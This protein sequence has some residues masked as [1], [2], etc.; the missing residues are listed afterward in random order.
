M[1]GKPGRARPHAGRAPGIASCAAGPASAATR[2]R[3]APEWPQDDGTPRIASCLAHRLRACSRRVPRPALLDEPGLPR[4]EGGGQSWLA[5]HHRCPGS[6][7]DFEPTGGAAAFVPVAFP[8]LVGT[9][10]GRLEAAECEL[11]GPSDQFLAVCPV[12]VSAPADAGG[13]AE[14]LQCTPGGRAPGVAGPSGAPPMGM[15]RIISAA[16]PRSSCW[17]QRPA[18]PVS[19]AAG[20]APRTTS[21]SRYEAR[22]SRGYLVGMSLP[23]LPG[24]AALLER[25]D[26]LFVSRPQRRPR[27]AGHPPRR[28][29]FRFPRLC[30]RRSRRPVLAEP[31]SFRPGADVWS[32]AADAAGMSPLLAMRGDPR[33][34]EDLP[35][36]VGAPSSVPGL[37]QARRNQ[38][39]GAVLARASYLP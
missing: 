11:A 24:R 21:R 3:T 23:L 7:L 28:R 4:P 17:R 37:D 15:L 1:S 38:R 32:H 39:N 12:L 14:D 30:A 16:E 5:E 10:E 27:S 13:L 2:P 25:G 20:T 9:G 33:S 19:S 18:S 29:K 36:A 6:V 8:D 34:R 31:C 35:A 22:M 26:N